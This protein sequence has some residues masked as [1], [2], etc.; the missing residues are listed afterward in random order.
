MPDCIHRARAAVKQRTRYSCLA[1]YLRAALHCVT[2]TNRAE[3]KH[4]SFASKTHRAVRRI[5]LNVAHPYFLPRFG[6]FFRR[7]HLAIRAH[8]APAADERCDGNV[9]RASSFVRKFCG[10]L[11][12]GKNFRRNANRFAYCASVHL[13]DLAPRTIKAELIF[14]PLNFRKRFLTR[15]AE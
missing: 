8:E 3:I 5:K 9:K 15:R 12:Q 10:A 1:Q 4:H 14:K 2:F 6:D 13:R 7:G 11:Q